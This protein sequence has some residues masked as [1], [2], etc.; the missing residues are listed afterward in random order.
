MGKH[1]SIVIR[2]IR[3]FIPM[4]AAVSF[5][6]CT[7]TAEE[8]LPLPQT[9]FPDKPN[10]SN[11]VIDLTDRF[12]GTTGTLNF[13][14]PEALVVESEDSLVSYDSEAKRLKYEAGSK[15][16]LL[17]TDTGADIQAHSL[18]ADM[19]TKQATLEG[20]LSIYQGEM[21]S[22]AAH[23]IYNWENKNMDAYDVRTKAQGLLI[24]S[25]HI[26]Y[27]KDAK[28]ETYMLIHDAYVS[29]DDV[30]E[31]TSW[32][33]A[34]EL[35]V[36]PGDYGRLTRLSVAGRDYD[37]PVPIIGWFSFSHSL[38]P[39]EGYLPSIGTKSIWGTYL[40][41]RYGFLL[42]NRRVENGIPVADYVLSTHADYRSRRGFA[43]GIDLKDVAMK[44]HLGKS[45]LSFYYIQDESPN[46]NPTKQTR[47]NISGKRYRLALQ[48]T[49]RLSDTKL[50]HSQQNWTAQVNA[51]ILSDRYVLRD[52]FEELSRIDNTPDN[53]VILTGKT[54]LSQMQLWGRF[55]PND[56]YST[57]ERTEFSYYRVRTALAKT[58]I[59]Y[60][61]RNSIAL[62]RQYL[63]L[64][65]RISY[66]NKLNELRNPE[67]ENYYGR[68]LNT[69]AFAR[70][71]STHEFAT[72][73]HILRFL[74]VTP[75]TGVGY[76]GYY[77]VDN[78]GSDNR[79]LGY[80]G[81]NFDIKFYREFSQVRL[82]WLYGKGLTHI[83]RPYATFSQCSISS[84]NP[85]VPKLDAW[86][87]TLSNSS[88]NPMAL[89]LMGFTSIDSWGT[90]TIWRMGVAN[91]F[92][93]TVDGSTHTLLN[94]N[95]FLD[96][97]VENPNTLSD[98]SNL[99]SVISFHPT[100]L[101][102]LYLES[103]TPTIKNGDGFSQYNIS[104]SIQPLRWFEYSV[105]YSYISNH[106]LIR[107][108]SQADFRTVIRLDEKHSLAGQWKWAI[109]DKR[110]PIQQYGIFRK[111]GPWYLGATLFLRNNGGKKETGFGVSFT[112]GETGTALPIEF[113]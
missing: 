97:N 18:S 29:T 49:W 37:I 62:L 80:I 112:L 42:G 65:Q 99:Y 89:D 38:N 74:N 9:V 47:E 67:L 19:E 32:I 35:T 50:F 33:G 64:E 52:F 78:V 55:A 13:E 30:E 34:G 3:M 76:S 113:F 105:G 106:S 87:T 90:W 31:P 36:Y 98:F 2:H 28:G 63:P 103:Q 61:T 46:I 17:R 1:Q 4:L 66:R 60:E 100:Q 95:I 27:K 70:V 79:F 22:R 83:F 58:R 15:S 93:T 75:K 51:N 10:T 44:K 41:N 96:Y 101:C 110:L 107:D 102:T 54:K 57:G 24:R 111:A 59:T 68:L 5:L 11:P 45:G 82:P 72:N 48:S 56:Y 40:Q 20:P 69:S 91:N 6:P 12:I 21:F 108:A 73:F 8:L 92:T 23:G 81:C 88:S 7:G 53:S 77:D 39:E 16:L 26:E 109:E 85:R 104:L 94:W 25:S 43:G 71:N 14:I 86:S 84:S